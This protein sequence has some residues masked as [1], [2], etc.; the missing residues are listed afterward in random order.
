MLNLFEWLQATAFTLTHY[1]PFFSTERDFSNNV[2]HFLSALCFIYVSHECFRFVKSEWENK[3]KWRYTSKEKPGVY[4]MPS[5]FDAKSFNREW[6]LDNG[7]CRPLL[8]KLWKQDI[9]VMENN[10]DAL[11]FICSSVCRCFRVWVFF[12]RIETILTQ[13]VECNSMQQFT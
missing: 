7:N 11:S 5:V 6:K 9:W 8:H 13:I 4:K 2:L 1:Y 10:T 12:C 3:S